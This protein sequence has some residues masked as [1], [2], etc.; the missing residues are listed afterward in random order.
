MLTGLLSALTGCSGSTVF[1]EPVVPNAPK[2][3][4]RDCPRPVLLPERTITQSEA[5]KFWGRDRAALVTC[6]D[7]HG[8]LRDYYTGRDSKLRGQR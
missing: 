4:A 6:R 2:E 8:A 5:E 3:L 7:R 1:V